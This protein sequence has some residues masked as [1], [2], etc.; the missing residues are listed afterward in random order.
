MDPLSDL[1]ILHNPDENEIKREPSIFLL[2][3]EKN[4]KKEGLNKNTYPP[5]IFR[6]FKKIILL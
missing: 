6:N 2:K 4:T 1:T 5:N 3:N